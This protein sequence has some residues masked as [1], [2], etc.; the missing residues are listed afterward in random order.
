M[1]RDEV[2]ERRD[3]IKYV[4]RFYSKPSKND[5]LDMARRFE[6]SVA[7]IILD[8]EKCKMQ[9][10]DIPVGPRTDPKLRIYIKER[11]G[12]T[13]Q[14]CGTSNICRP[15]SEHVITYQMGGHTKPYNLV[16]ACRSCNAIKGRRIWIPNNINEIYFINKDWY[17]KIINDYRYQKTYDTTAVCN[18]RETDYGQNCS[19]PSF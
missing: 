13:C 2:V 14:Y 4:M 8:I 1:H 6:C 7:T 11:D 12:N 18:Q 3:H 9:N 19:V 10:N 16:C 15:V 17:W 5:I